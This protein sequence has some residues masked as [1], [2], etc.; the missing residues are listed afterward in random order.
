MYQI[1]WPIWVNG[2]FYCDFRSA[3]R[4]LA[5]IKIL[6][7]L[8]LAS[9]T[10][11]KE[12]NQSRNNLIDWIRSYNY[13]KNNIVQTWY[14]SKWRNRTIL[15]FWQGTMETNLLF[16]LDVLKF[17]DRVGSPQTSGY[18]TGQIS[19]SKKKWKYIFELVISKYLI[20]KKIFAILKIFRKPQME[21]ISIV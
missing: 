5:M 9:R 7:F 16:R 2:P 20:E 18:F 19:K 12:E 8:S 3:M 1:I 17:E 11:C 4:L 10:S 13:L 21:N 14:F 6:E 15:E